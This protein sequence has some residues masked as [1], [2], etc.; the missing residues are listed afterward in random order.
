MT[1]AAYISDEDVLLERERRRRVIARRA[2]PTLA[3]YVERT[4]ALHLEPWQRIICERLQRLA[5]ERGARLLIHG[6]PQF[7]KSVIISQRFPAWALGTAP[8]L[9]FRIA[10]YNISHAAR[11]TGVALDLLR[12]T[13]PND[14]ARPPSIAAR[15]EWSTKARAGLRDANPS[16]KAL[17]LGTGFTG[18]GVDTLI[19]DDPYKNAQEA[20]SP[21]VN[22][23]LRDWWQQVVL[24]RLNPDAN[25]VVMFHRWWEGDFAGWLIDSG[26]WELLRFP[27]VADGQPG[28]P[29]GRA[30]GEPLSPRYSLDHLAQKRLDMGTAFEA[31]YQ[32]TP[33]PAEGTMFKAG[34]VTFVDA[35]PAG[36]AFVRGWDIGA[37][38]G[39]GDPTASALLYRKPGGGYGVANAR[40]GQWAT[41]ERDRIIRETAESDQTAY[42]AV[43]Q[44][45]P[46]DPG[47]AGKSQ[48]WAFVKLLDGFTVETTTESGDKATRADPLS[49]Q[50]NAGNVEIVRGA[51]NR[52]YLE[53]M[54]AF[55]QGKNDHYTDASSR[56]YARL[57][58]PQPKPRPSSSEV[59]W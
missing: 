43:A 28:D 35:P 46:Q 50:W 21:A 18:L 29:T 45:L 58:K 42:G 31:L 3:A 26:G 54:L 9:R 37:S 19:I 22:V 10:C 14:D 6:P 39:S 15:D 36:A 48:A 40:Q 11:F 34:R 55:P 27:A 7:G 4:T 51:W 44:S 17:G 13:A 59:A 8:L 33:Y 49:S 52:A 32:G 25:V 30:R 24:S 20:R 57:S 47:A 1:T 56:A 38:A 2:P 16:M 53:A 5:S 41:D 23:M 12:E